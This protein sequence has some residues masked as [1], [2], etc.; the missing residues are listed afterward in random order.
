MLDIQL[1][2]KSPQVVEQALLR[3]GEDIP[4]E[5]ILHLDE[6]RRKLLQEVESMR[7]NQNQ[8]NRLVGRAKGTRTA[9]DLSALVE[10]VRLMGY[11]V[12]PNTASTREGFASFLVHL[13]RET[14]SQVLDQRQADIRR[15]DKKLESL[16]LY[17]PN[18]PHPTVPEGTGDEDNVTVRTWGE[19]PTFPFTPRPHYEIGEA[20]GIIDFERGVKLSGT[21]FYVLK[22]A[23]ARL[24][25]A[26]ITFML[27]VH[28]REH[29]YTEAYLPFMVKGECLVGTGSLPRFGDNLYHDAE[30]DYWWVPTA[31]VPLTNLHRDEI[32]EPG[33][34]PLCYTAYTA[35]FRRE[36]MAAGKETRG[37]KRGH[38]FD[39]VE[40]YKFTEPDHSYEELEK[41]VSDAEDIVQRLGLPYRVRMLCAGEMGFQSA[42]SY[43]IDVWASGVGEWLEAS[44][45]SNCT[46]FQARRTRIR[47]RPEPGA[48]PQLVHTLNG[49]G[50]ALPRMVIAVLENYQREDGTVS[51]PPALQPYLG[52]EVIS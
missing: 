43:D 8:L 35:C 16:L 3:R 1:I 6:T 5:R 20:L 27:D 42:K 10:Q 13:G 31:E 2:R 38:Q 15:L 30:E 12:G 44:S 7:A 29:G 32:L 37:L 25:R 22:G 49:S 28:T 51:V 40:M 34:L 45:C 4:L 36:K 21:R 46:D 41:L 9:D 33:T 52:T 18:L 11:E 47:Y 24:Q 23:G 48:R 39:K 50:L 17:L 19:P 26:L 14:L